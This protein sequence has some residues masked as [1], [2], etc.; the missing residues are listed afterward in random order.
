MIDGSTGDVIWAMWGKKNMF[1]DV[2]VNGTAKFAF[3]HEARVSGLNR[4]TL[5]DNHRTND[6][7]F[8]HQEM[9]SRGLE[10]QYDLDTKT[11][12]MVNEWKHPQ[13]LLS[14][15][16]GGVQRTSTGNVVVAWGQNPMYTEYT[17]EGELAMD[18]QRAPVKHIE[19]GI[20]DVITYRIWKGNWVG[21]PSWGPNISCDVHDKEHPFYVSWNGATEVHK[22]VLVR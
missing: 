20:F 3:Q 22:W 6:N 15:S 14:A 18:I 2:T 11:V 4:I 5:F 19:H 16:R 12:W 21:Q 9:C 1:T 13:S 7:G 10:I 8:C 17:P